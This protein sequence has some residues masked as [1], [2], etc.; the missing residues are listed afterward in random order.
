[1][2]RWDDFAKIAFITFT[3][4]FLVD[5]TL[6]M[7]LR[8]LIPSE[9][10]QR[11]NLDHSPDVQ[12]SLKCPFWIHDNLSLC[13]RARACLTMVYAGFTF[14]PWVPWRRFVQFHGN[15]SLP[16]RLVVHHRHTAISPQPMSD[17]WFVVVAKSW[18]RHEHLSAPTSAK[19]RGNFLPKTT[20]IQS[21]CPFNSGCAPAPVFQRLITWFAVAHMLYSTCN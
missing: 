3:V 6:Y 13:L 2:G 21:A 17:A 5:V 10:S 4:I 19:K 16:Y 9:M 14:S 20:P 15:S 8:P 18:C 12:S 11:V 7:N 1:M